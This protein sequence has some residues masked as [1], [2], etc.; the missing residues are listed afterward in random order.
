MHAH[1]HTPPVS[2]LPTRQHRVHNE[3]EA[4]R[5]WEENW[6]WLAAPPAGDP[7]AAAA[8]AAGPT[9]SKV[10]TK[11][12][13]D[14]FL[15]SHGG[16][17]TSTIKLSLRSQKHQQS[18]PQ[19]HYKVTASSGSASSSLEQPAQATRSGSGGGDD[20]VDEFVRQYMIK[21][22][23]SSMRSV[24]SGPHS[25]MQGPAIRHTGT[26]FACACCLRAAVMC[27]V[28]LSPLAWDGAGCS[29]V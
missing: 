19:G 5:R 11:D 7:A 13:M 23:G 27:V 1:T 14:R 25:H 8:A 2:D 26:R 10:A 18:Q 15:A 22:G 17:C 24:G 4:G 3:M 20:A 9:S 21:C 6:G 16:S 29:Y 28:S 12:S